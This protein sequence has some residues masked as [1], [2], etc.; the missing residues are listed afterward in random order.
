LSKQNILSG[1]RAIRVWPLNPR[2]MDDNISPNSLYI[3][4]DDNNHTNEDIGN[5]DDI[6]NGNP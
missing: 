3:A 6:G 5:L 2:A 4:R 1:F